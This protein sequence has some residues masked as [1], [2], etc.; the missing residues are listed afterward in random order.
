MKIFGSLIAF[1]LLTVLIVYIL[2]FENQSIKTDFLPSQFE[3]CGR[4]IT[5]T[6]TQYIEIT[7]WLVRNKD[8]WR[9]D[10]NTQV[11][12]NVYRSAAFTVV[13]YETGVSVSYKTDDGYPRFIKTIPHKLDTTCIAGS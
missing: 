5:N 2:L 1:I 9:R 8:G 4:T 10:W 7:D 6:D 3:N 11:A 13:V 12:G